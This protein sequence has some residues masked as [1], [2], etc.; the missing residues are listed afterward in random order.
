MSN[1][2]R[3]PLYTWIRG[4]TALNILSVLLHLILFWLCVAWEQPGLLLVVLCFS[5]LIGL[6][7]AKRRT[8]GAEKTRV[9][10]RYI[11]NGGVWAFSL[12]MIFFIAGALLLLMK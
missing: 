12:L 1:S 2:P 3:S 6:G 8:P 9:L 7:L 5:L 4:T 10:G 11:F